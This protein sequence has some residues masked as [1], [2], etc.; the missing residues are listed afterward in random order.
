MLVI[1]HQNVGKTTIC[2]ELC[3]IASNVF[4]DHQNKEKAD[5]DGNKLTTESLVFLE[6]NLFDKPSFRKLT[7]GIA[8][9]FI[10]TY[11]VDDD[12]SFDYVTTL[13]RDVHTIM[14]MYIII[15]YV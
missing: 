7:I 9:A 11:A 5:N 2:D 10:L 13:I 3:T 15:Y 1:G 8:D 14:G 4:G 6:A 12:E